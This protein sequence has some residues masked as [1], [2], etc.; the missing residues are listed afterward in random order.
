MRA[1]APPIAQGE[2]RSLGDWRIGVFLCVPPPSIKSVK[3][4]SSNINLSQI[5]YVF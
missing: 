2:G 5:E 3:K 4:A 1:Y